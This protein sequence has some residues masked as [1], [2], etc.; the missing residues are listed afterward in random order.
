VAEVAQVIQELEMETLEVLEAVVHFMVVRA[1]VVL[2]IILVQE[3]FYN[4]VI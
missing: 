2:Q 1:Q 4:K 3:L